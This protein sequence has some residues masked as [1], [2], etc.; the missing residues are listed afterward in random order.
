MSISFDEAKDTVAGNLSLTGSNTERFKI[1]DSLNAAQ[2]EILLTVDPAHLTNGVRSTKGNLAENTARY[3]WPA[4]FL[5]FVRMWVDYGNEITDTNPGREVDYKPYG[6]H[7][8][9]TVLDTM[10]SA[11]FPVAGRCENGWELRPIPT[12]NQTKGWRVE[13]I[14]KLPD[15]NGDQDSLLREVFKDAMIFKATELSASKAGG[16]MLPVA[17]KF[18]GHYAEVIAPYLPK[19]AI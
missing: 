10:P 9:A 2:R 15:M 7:R 13:Y 19:E 18:A 17:E 4:E 16:F 11:D 8:Q 1:T 6:L 5:K 12:S 3:Q 14:W